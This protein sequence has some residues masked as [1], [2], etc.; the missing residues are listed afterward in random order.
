M[1]GCDGGKRR[2]GSAD[3]LGFHLFVGREESKQQ[4]WLPWLCKCK[5]TGHQFKG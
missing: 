5:L 4:E 2:G 3:H 1:Y